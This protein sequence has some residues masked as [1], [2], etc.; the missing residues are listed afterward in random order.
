M[1]MKSKKLMRN[2]FFFFLWFAFSGC[3]S[4]GGEIVPYIVN[5]NFVMESNIS[6]YE[7][8]GVDLYFLNKSEKS[9]KSFTIVFFLFDN[10]GEPAATTKNN[11]VFKI[12][13]DL[14]PMESINLCLNLD[15]YVNYVP[16]DGFFIDY[17]YISSIIYSDDSEWSDP[18]GLKAF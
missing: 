11:I 7:I 13:E 4:F 14:D 8:C 3:K 17:L 2:Y 15:K 1:K 10:E 6:E 16:E 12:D 5:G 18:L 9:V